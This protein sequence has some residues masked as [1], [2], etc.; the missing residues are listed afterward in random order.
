MGTVLEQGRTGCSPVLFLVAVPGMAGGPSPSSAGRIRPRSSRHFRRRLDAGGGVLARYPLGVG[1]GGGCDRDARANVALVR[2]PRPCW[3][4][5]PGDRHADSSS[6]RWRPHGPTVGSGRGSEPRGGIEIR[7]GVLDR[8]HFHGWRPRMEVVK[9]IAQADALLFPSLHDAAGWVV[10]EAV[11]LG[12]PVVCLDRGGPAL[13]AEGPGHVRV[14]VSSRVVED[15]AAGL[16]RER[17]DLGRSPRIGGVRRGCLDYSPIGMRGSSGRRRASARRR[18]TPVVEH[19]GDL[20]AG[21][22]TIG[23]LRRRHPNGRPALL[24]PNMPTPIQARRTW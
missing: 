4:S 16:V 22:M 6:S 18:A 7:V 8:V 17:P 20:A 13:L 5:D 24:R 19:K 2:D 15:L 23:W 12:T 3:G 10:A 9:A 11:S 1:T 14:E 21:A